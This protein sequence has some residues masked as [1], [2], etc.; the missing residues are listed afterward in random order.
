MNTIPADPLRMPVETQQRPGL[1]NLFP[2]TSML[3]PAVG[4]PASTR[5]CCR[6]AH[7]GLHSLL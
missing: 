4:I 1:G 5:Q 7:F 3:R 2:G 6:Q